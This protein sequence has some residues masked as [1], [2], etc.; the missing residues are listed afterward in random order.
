MHTLR[1]PD[2]RP[3]W[4]WVKLHWRKL[5]LYC[6]GGSLALL[7]LVQLFYPTDRLLPFARADGVN[8]GW[9]TRTEATNLL[10]GAYDSYKLPIYMGNDT[11]PTVTPTL[12]QASIKV[13]NT[14]RVNH[15]DYAWYWRLLPSS[16]F[17]A[18]NL[19]VGKTPAASFSNNF[20][21]Y[22]DEKLMPECHRAPVN[23]SLKANGDSL[24]VVSAQD[25][26]SCARESVLKTL[27]A[28]KPDLT[29]AYTIRV[30][31]E[32]LAPAVNDA[33]A[34]SLADELKSRVGN[35]VSLMVNGAVVKVAAKD[36]YAWLDFSAKDAALIAQI[37]PDRASAWLQANIAAKVAVQPG[38]SYIKT[39]D[40]TELS[41]VNGSDGVALNT[42]AT[43][44]SLQQVIDGS[45]T[46]ALVATKVVPPTE[47]YTRTY[48]ATDAGFTALLA[49][50][51]KDHPGTFGVS[52]VELDGKKRRADY[53]GDKQFVT[54]STY[55]LFVAFSVLKQID[56]GKRDWTATETCFNKMITYSD[57]T[58]AEGLLQ[59]VGVST[60]TKD[61][62]AVGLKNSTFMKTG[63]PFT[64]ASDL[65]LMLGML[66]SQQN[67]SATN[68][69][70][71]INAM[72]ANVFRKGIP[73]GVNGTVANKVGFMDNLL[74]DAA[75]VYS[76]SGA[77]VLA[78]MTEGSS[79]ATI[80]DLAKQIDTLH[81][82]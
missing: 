52:L 10:N 62:Q 68:R 28:V 43:I 33:A 12:K 79:W 67:F 50:Y 25:G 46:A 22:V 55:K 38:I 9:R 48:S 60:V 40:F 64:T 80:A 56:A 73:A 53:Q 45:L 47:Q 71:L 19:N 16:L 13:D 30:A 34:K 7:I 23:A 15:M 3:H 11:K 6:G 17:W 36:V 14:S 81:T 69:Q 39:L 44:S 59:S 61:I 21:T 37:N 4:R 77:Y 74:H 5:L 41:R 63:G 26:G 24:S 18:Q 58:C 54:A 2:L 70:R 32:N 20:T 51:A 82:Q 72:T 42:T 29:H 66:Q 8:L 31:Q 1:V 27:K 75:I 35:D 57:N 78:I 49:N 65:T 76:P